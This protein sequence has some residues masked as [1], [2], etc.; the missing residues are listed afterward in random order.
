MTVAD[1]R[2]LLSKYSDS[3]EVKIQLTA[4]EYGHAELYVG[5]DCILEEEN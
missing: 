4:S 3:D 5:N 1:L 2:E